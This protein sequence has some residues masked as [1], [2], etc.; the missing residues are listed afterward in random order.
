[1]QLLMF[2]ENAN[3]VHLCYNL[4]S[5]ELFPSYVD[6][7]ILL[8]DWDKE[9]VQWV[10]GAV[11]DIGWPVSVSNIFDGVSPHLRTAAINAKGVKDRKTA[12]VDLHS[13]TSRGISDGPMF[14]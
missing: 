13:T 10:V 2:C 6:P 3:Q 9:T 12:L 8:L 7:E 4:V 1:M 14:C 11:A 5:S